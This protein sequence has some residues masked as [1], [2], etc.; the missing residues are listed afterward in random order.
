MPVVHTVLQGLLTGMAKHTGRSGYCKK[1]ITVLTVKQEVSLLGA[2]LDC[3]A[4]QQEIK[5]ALALI[6]PLPEHVLEQ[7]AV[8]LVD[9][10]PPTCVCCHLQWGQP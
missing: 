7:K 6:R 5:D 3:Q 10:P 1:Q 4:L 9:R 2:G 8:K